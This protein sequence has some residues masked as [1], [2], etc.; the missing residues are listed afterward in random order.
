MFSLK[1]KLYLVYNVFEYADFVRIDDMPPI[2]PV[3]K[4]IKDDGSNIAVTLPYEK[5]YG[6]KDVSFN[7]LELSE[8][9]CGKEN[10]LCVDIDE[11]KRKITFLKLKNMLKLKKSVDI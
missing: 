6:F 1:S 10:Y 11:V 2:I 7:E 9:S 5:Y 4:D 3:L 8:A